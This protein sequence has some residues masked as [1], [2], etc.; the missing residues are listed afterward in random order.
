VNDWPLVVTA[1]EIEKVRPFFRKYRKNRKPPIMLAWLGC[2]TAAHDATI[3]AANATLQQTQLKAE[4]I[5]QSSLQS[6]KDTLRNT[7]D[8]APC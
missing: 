7:G 1:T 6:A 2:F 8:T 5:K 4:A 3:R